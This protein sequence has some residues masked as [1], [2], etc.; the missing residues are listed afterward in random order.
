MTHKTSLAQHKAANGSRSPGNKPHSGGKDTDTKQQ[1]CRPVGIGVKRP[2][3]QSTARH[4]KN[5]A[6]SQIAQLHRLNF[7]SFQGPSPEF[8]L[9]FLFPEYHSYTS[10]SRLNISFIRLIYT[11]GDNAIA[12][13]EER[14][15]PHSSESAGNKVRKLS[16]RSLIT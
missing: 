16:N 13:I 11:S 14:I 12:P 8:P 4:L 3:A 9:N 1:P 2:L 5:C 15:A 7:N 10:S 6:I